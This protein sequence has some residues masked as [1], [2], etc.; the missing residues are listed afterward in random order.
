[1]SFGL[2]LNVVLGAALTVLCAQVV[3]SVLVGSGS[4]TAGP[5][6]RTWEFHPDGWIW[7]IPG[8]FLVLAH[9]VFARAHGIEPTRRPRSFTRRW[10]QPGRRGYLTA[11]LVSSLPQI[12]GWSAAAF[13]IVVGGVGL[14]LPGIQ[15]VA[16]STTDWP[17]W[18]AALCLTGIPLVYGAA[19]ATAKGAA[20]LGTLGRRLVGAPGGPP[21]WW[22]TI[23]GSLRRDVA[24]VLGTLLLSALAYCA[25]V[26][27][28]WHAAANLLTGGSGDTVPAAL[29]VLA[30]VGLRSFG[31]G[32]RSSLI[33]YY[34]DRLSYAYLELGP[35]GE[36]PTLVADPATRRLA[37]QA[38]VPLL[39]EL[40]A[41]PRLR[42][43]A[44][45]NLRDAHLMPARRR[46]T[47]LVFS[48]VGVGLTDDK[49][50]G[51]R[52]M[53]LPDS[54]PVL[55]TVADGVTSSA[56]AIS[57][58]AG[59]DS[60]HVG[61]ARLLLTLVNIR[62]GMW[63]PNPYWVE[64]GAFA[65]GSVAVR[66]LRVWD[67]TSHFSVVAEAV[68]VPSVFHPWLYV[69]DGGH[70][71]NLGLVESL[72]L[73]PRV[74]VVLDGT[75]DDED[76]FTAMGVACATARM[77][78]GVEVDFTP[79]P[80]QRGNQHSAPAA[81]IVC[82]ATFPDGY[83]CLVVVVKSVWTAGQ[84]WDVEAYRRTH[85]GFPALSDELETYGEF[86]AEAFRQ[87]GWT[88]LDASLV[89]LQQALSD[90]TSKPVSSNSVS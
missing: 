45:A 28:T 32:Q 2:A 65:G 57:P 36:D 43:V 46:C 11:W 19:T 87:L 83:S 51:G 23:Q 74:V 33:P 3:A 61:A 86:D 10:V 48:S 40:V 13:L 80:M 54:F 20:G 42:M 12:L 4:L 90:V 62:L 21:R 84:T 31:P 17:A 71:D 14:L 55:M 16:T 1:M 78:L 77:D 7:V 89:D 67:R 26:L 59:R 27:A 47:P 24:P 56:A 41:G 76:D 18:A 15:S 70:Y 60:R 64:A 37:H 82:T 72:R 88:Q 8:V 35:R 49:L 79:G 5:G 58:M 81:H 39:N 25:L 53:P 29:S 44:A 9:F 85:P 34:R 75:S 6:P 50:P 63:V 52:S 73:R 68:G 66:L 69:T 22:V 30:L 38:P